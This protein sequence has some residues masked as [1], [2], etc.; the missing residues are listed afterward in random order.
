MAMIMNMNPHLGFRKAVNF[1]SFFF[2]NFSDVVQR[3][4]GKKYK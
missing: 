3:I 1:K 4:K 2:F